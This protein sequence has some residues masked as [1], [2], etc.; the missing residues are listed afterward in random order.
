MQRTG[1]VH[2]TAYVLNKLPKSKQRQAKAKLR[3]IWMAGSRKE[4]EKT[5]DAFASAYEAKYPSAV[6]CL[7]KD[8][9][10]L[11]AFDDFP[12]EPW[13]HIQTTNPIESVFATVR[14]RTVRTKGCLSHQ[15]AT[16]RVFKLVMPAASKTWRKLKGNNQLKTSA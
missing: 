11:L 9:D 16:A 1:W 6:A 4:A 12:A 14:H 13:Q 3:Y 15:T 10:A 2:K 8:R 5:M 7:T